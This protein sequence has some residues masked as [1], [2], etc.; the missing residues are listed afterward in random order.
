MN[1]KTSSLCLAALLFNSA[2]FAH[3]YVESPPGR[4]YQCKLGKNSNCGAVQWEP[5]SLEQSSGFPESNTPPDG[6]LASA[7]RDTYA[8]MDEQSPTRWAKTAIKSG[9]NAFTWYHTAPHKTTNWRY[10]ITRQNWDPSK[11]LTRS[12]FESTPFC[13][14]DGNSAAP[15]TKATHNCDVPLRTGYQ[16]IYAVWEI[17]DTANSF[18][19]VIDVDFSGSNS[20]GTDE[21][22][23][24]T[25]NHHT[26]WTKLL[27]GLIS[28]KD[29]KAGNE[30]VAHFFNA[31]GEV[32][33]LRTPLSIASDAQGASKQWSYDLAQA[34]N[35]AHS[36]IRAGVKDSE[37]NIT[38]VHGDN[39]VYANEE[40]GLESMTIYYEE[41]A[42]K[43]AVTLSDVTA[44]KI[45][46][47]SATVSLRAT[48]KGHISLN[49]SV[50][51]HGGTEKGS[52]TT[53]L[54]DQ[55]SLLKINLTDVHAGH[56]MLRY[57]GTSSEGAVVSQGVIDLMLEESAALPEPTPTYKY[58]FPK[59]MKAYKAGTRVLQ[60][61]DGKVYQ[62]R[63]FPYSG[64]CVQWSKSANQYEPG[65]GFAWEMAW[66]EVS[67]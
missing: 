29:L 45:T 42:T 66:T 38:P 11:P 59:N 63:P 23:E 61:K 54:H 47:G 9:M 30:V 37:G 24:E 65:V 55:T 64:Y 17:A 44:S 41:S 36:E 35:A 25:H 60:P 31:H 43:D 7:G 27:N 67:Q 1:L 51:D 22:E 50:N 12:A 3:G 56:H 40:S 15:A 8:Q 26:G 57:S 16:V 52:V 53:T 39:P 4:A 34:I 62:C 21:H 33:S 5:Q 6:Q 18:Y 14:I 28:G 58:V 19:Q 2:V 48:A 49:A 20:E 10:Y 32:T 13:K 46:E